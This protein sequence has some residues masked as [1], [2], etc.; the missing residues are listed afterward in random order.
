M[1]SS[2]KLVA[3]FEEG[4]RAAGQNHPVTGTTVV[5]SNVW[6]HAAVTYDATTGTW[7]LYL[8]GRAR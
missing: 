4:A 3:D 7:K 5:T 6:H 1:P 8:D 2:N